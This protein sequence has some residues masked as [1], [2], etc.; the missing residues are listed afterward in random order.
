MSVVG[1]KN[2]HNPVIVAVCLLHN[3]ECQTVGGEIMM[4]PDRVVLIGGIVTSSRVRCGPSLPL[5]VQRVF[6]VPRVC[7][8]VFGEIAFRAGYRMAVTRPAVEKTEVNTRARTLSSGL[9]PDVL[10]R[11]FTENITR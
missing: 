6:R 10:R 7:V 1:Q 5:A 9:P 2:G 4:M 11:L 3:L 8:A